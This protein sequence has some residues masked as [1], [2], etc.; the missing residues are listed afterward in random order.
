MTMNMLM[1]PTAVW[2]LIDSF[3]HASSSVFEGVE[4]AARGLKDEVL[5][6]LCNESAQKEQA[7][8]EAAKNVS[9]RKTDIKKQL[10]SCKREVDA[11]EKSL[12]KAVTK[13]CNELRAT[14]EAA[15]AEKTAALTEQKQGLEEEAESLKKAREGAKKTLSSLAAE[16]RPIEVVTASLELKQELAAINQRSEASPPV[17]EANLHVMC[18]K[19]DALVGEVNEFGWSGAV[20]ADASQCTLS[21]RGEELIMGPWGT[22]DVILSAR[23]KLGQ[24]L[25]AGG[26]DVKAI[27][28]PAGDVVGRVTVEDMED[29]TYAIR[30]KARATDGHSAPRDLSLSIEVCGSAIHGSPFPI[31]SL[32]SSIVTTP[33][34][35]KALRGFLPGTKRLELCYRASRDGWTAADF[36]RLCDGK[37]PTL[38]LA[39]EEVAGYI[40]G[41]YTAVAW[42]SVSG[43]HFDEHAFLFS[44]LSPRSLGSRSVGLRD[45][46]SVTSS[47]EPVKMPSKG[48]DRYPAVRHQASSGPTFGISHDLALLCGDRQPRSGSSRIGDAYA[49]PAGQTPTFL[50]GS[51]DFKL[52]ELE[53]FLVK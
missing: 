6:G 1:S 25:E 50:V 53:V 16:E 15:A 10:A 7:L 11:V 18:T 48:G 17:R 45:F 43:T 34:R 19:L 2:Y 31:F 9:R 36:H 8:R 5:S 12:I 30:F 22:F 38:V 23:D 28:E 52:S 37:G 42:S 29:G 4:R 32:S 13:R 33:E 44:I 51:R 24:Q 21:K 39:R 40:F 20:D 46:L 49:P 26:V 14:L 35:I 41:G 47:I 3:L 27:V